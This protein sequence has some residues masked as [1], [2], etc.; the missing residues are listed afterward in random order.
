[1]TDPC[2]EIAGAVAALPDGHPMAEAT[3]PGEWEFRYLAV[4]ADRWGHGLGA[5][6]VAAVEARA[7]IGGAK[8]VVLRVVDNN[9]R[10]LRLYERLGY[11]HVPERSISFES[12]DDPVRII[13]L[14]LHSKAI[15]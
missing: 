7:K 1:L 8:R 15:S 12:M 3:Q 6:L 13:N 4:R 14:L 9:P 2:R 10:A 5:R 11:T